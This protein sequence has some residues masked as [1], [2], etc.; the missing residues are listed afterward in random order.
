[1][2]RSPAPASRHRTVTSSRLPICSTV[3]P[4]SSEP[5]ANRQLQDQHRSSPTEKLPTTDGS[6]A[7]MANAGAARADVLKVV[8]RPKPLRIFAARL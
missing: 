7:A 6:T 5:A 3:A 4:S 2:R 8:S 1:M